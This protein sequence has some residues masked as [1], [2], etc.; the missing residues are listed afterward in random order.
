MKEENDLYP[1]NYTTVMKKLKR[2]HT[3]GKVFHA[4]GFEEQTLLKCL[5]YPI[6]STHLIQSLPK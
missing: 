2:T 5:H 6:Q 3:N 1:E 4:H